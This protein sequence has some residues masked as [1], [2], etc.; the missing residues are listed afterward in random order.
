MQL[1]R[2]PTFTEVPVMSTQ[3]INGLTYY[4]G[5]DLA[6]A[7]KQWGTGEK[8]SHSFLKGVENATVGMVDG[9][10]IY[11]GQALTAIGDFSDSEVLKKTGDLLLENGLRRINEEKYNMRFEIPVEQ[12]TW[13]DDLVTQFGQLLPQVGVGL[14]ASFVGGPVLGTAAGVGQAVAMD[15]ASSA[16]ARATKALEKSKQR[17][18]NENELAMLNDEIKRLSMDESEFGKEL[19]EQKIKA[20]QETLSKGYVEE[21]GIQQ[22]KEILK[23]NLQENLIAETAIGGFTGVTEAIGFGRLLNIFKGNKPA[24]AFLKGGATEATTEMI[25][26]SFQKVVNYTD[27]TEDFQGLPSFFQDIFYIGSLAFVAGGATSS[28][29][30]VYNKRRFEKELTPYFESQGMSKEEAQKSAGDFYDK[31]V[32]DASS[33]VASASKFSNDYR[34]K[35][36]E[37]YQSFYNSS[38][39]ALEESEA[40]FFAN[41]DEDSKAQYVSSNAKA[42]ANQ[43]LAEAFTRDMLSEDIVSGKDIVYSDGLLKLANSKQTNKIIEIQADNES[44]NNAINDLSIPK[45][46]KEKIINENNKETEQIKKKIRQSDKIYPVKGGLTKKELKSLNLNKMVVYNEEEV[47]LVGFNNNQAVVETADGFL[48]VPIKE[49]KPVEEKIKFENIEQEKTSELEEIKEDETKDFVYVQDKKLPVNY[50]IVELDSLITSNDTTG[51]VN[52]E[53]P[54]YLQNRD[55]S[56]KNLLAQIEDIANNIRPADVGKSNNLVYGSP[57]VTKENFVAVGNGRKLGIEKAYIYGKQGGYTDYLKSLGYD[58]TGFDKPILVRRLQDDYSKE[59]M[60]TLTNQAND[61]PNAALSVSETAINDARKLTDDIVSL[62]DSNFDIDEKPNRKFIVEAFDKIIPVNDKIRFS[63]SEG[64]ITAEGLNRIRNAT[65]AYVLPNKKILGDILES[66]NE[67]IKKSSDAI[68]QSSPKIVSFENKIKEGG[69]NKDYSIVE[70]LQQAFQLY[71]AAKKSGQNVRAYIKNKDMFTSFTEEQQAITEIFVSSKSSGQIRNLINNYIKIATIEGDTKQEVLF[72]DKKTKMQIIDS[73]MGKEKLYQE[74]L[75]E[76]GTPYTEPTIN[77][78]GVDR[79]TTNSTGKPIGTTKESLEAFYNWFGDSKVVDEDGRPLVVYHGTP[80]ALVYNKD[81]VKNVNNI[82]KRMYK[83]KGIPEKYK[84]ITIDKMLGWD[85]TINQF[86]KGNPDFKV[87]DE[88]IRNIKQYVPFDKFDFSM[89]GRNTSSDKGSGIFFSPS[90][91][92]AETF[93]YN[94]KTDL[95]GDI[96]LRPATA[97]TIPVYL[98]L[99]NPYIAKNIN[100]KQIA[101]YRDLGYDGII[102]T[103]TGKKRLDVKIDKEYIAFNPNQIKSTDNTTFRTDTDNIY[104]QGQAAKP[105]GYYDA[106]NKA[107]KLFN[108]ANAST[109]PH[110]TAHF[111]L[112]NMWEYVRSGNASKEYIDRFNKL[113]DFIGFDTSNPNIPMTEISSEKFATAY[114]QYLFKGVSIN[115]I[116]KGAFDNFDKWLQEVYKTQQDIIWRAGRGNNSVSGVVEMTPELE[117]FFNEWTTADLEPFSV[118][119]KESL[120]E[121]KEAIT[122]EKESIEEPT[123]EEVI[124]PKPSKEIIVKDDF[125]VIKSAE[126]IENIST[127][128]YVSTATKVVEN[129][130]SSFDNSFDNNTIEDKEGFS[131]AFEREKPFYENLMEQ[132]IAPL[133]YTK[134]KNKEEIDKAWTFVN[135]NLEQARKVVNGEEAPNGLLK[136]AVLSAYEIKMREMGNSYEALNALRE[137]SLFLTNAGQEIQMEGATSNISLE[138]WIRNI[139]AG[140][141]KSTANRLKIRSSKSQ[142]Y[143]EGYREE[144]KKDARMFAEE[145]SKSENKFK[146]LEQIIK[147]IDKKYGAGI[148]YQTDINSFMDLENI[149]LFDK[150]IKEINKR[151]GADLE[152]KDYDAIKVKWENW[153]NSQKMIE[154]NGNPSPE[155]WKAYR[156]L[157]DAVMALN[158]SSMPSLF[159]ASFSRLIML[160][161]I[162]SPV[163]N[164]ESNSIISISEKITKRASKK[165]LNDSYKTGLLPKQFKNDYFDYCSDVYNKSHINFST[166]KDFIDENSFGETMIHAQGSGLFRKV[167]RGLANI[168]FDFS[169]GKPDSWFKD[170]AFMDTLDLETSTQAMNEGLKGEEAIQRAVE[171]AKDAILLRPETALGKKIRERAQEDAHIATYTNDTFASERAIKLR[172]WLDSLAPNVMLGHNLMAFVKTVANVVSSGLEYSGGILK[173]AYNIPKIKNELNSIRNKERD[174]FSLDVQNAIN[175]GIRNGLGMILA[176]AILSVLDIEDYIPEYE[177]A[178]PSEK[179]RVRAVNGTYNAIKINGVWMSLEYF[180]P[181]MVPIACILSAKREIKELNVRGSLFDYVSEGVSVE[182]ILEFGSGY[183]KGVGSQILKIPGLREATEFFS[184][185]NDLFYAQNTEKA[186]VMML[187]DLYSFI[188][189]RTIPGIVGDVA[190][191]IDTKERD[192]RDFT[193]DGEE[194][195]DVIAKLFSVIPLLRETLPEAYDLT[196]GEPKEEGDAF[197]TGLKDLLFGARVKF[198]KDN[199]LANE[200]TRLKQS[201]QR[202]SLSDPTRYGLFKTLDKESKVKIR[203]DFAKLYYENANKLIRTYQY[204]KSSDEEKANLLNKSRSEVVKKL[205]NKYIKR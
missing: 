153:Q 21:E 175:A 159:V 147:R 170:R 187:D 116:I 32:Y 190:K 13:F 65:F 200:F 87:T 99:K 193:I 50:E 131:K 67:V 5:S 40:D 60:V 41:M 74:G 118:E 27:D 51:K 38:Y 152:V 94:I 197:V 68:M 11:G 125:P 149:L 33:L 205:K 163:L 86:I 104:L 124:T 109:L 156:K 145:L 194:Y 103:M 123:A 43:T 45:E 108:R 162:K 23:D 64:F 120:T 184:S 63:D 93:E 119:A 58:L 70:D 84:E 202:F 8:L 196:T 171:I 151:S 176:S 180:G 191:A 6:G 80:T 188:Q 154:K 29:I 17:A 81:Y 31:G 56:N 2:T 133:M 25:Q 121:E 183:L 73:L 85:E 143:V 174:S 165:I 53:Y 164:V 140:R 186:A 132:E 4:L 3:E 47:K 88:E 115:P 199:P 48:N 204:K 158:P 134:K 198:G 9:L 72:R 75:E 19:R 181:L 78:K 100:E 16:E 35:A 167:N 26:E 36:G 49:L 12:M 54:A 160:L 150:F 172:R 101:K 96:I 92:Q 37:L 178:F 128:E 182:D 69:I 157:N 127:E 97:G 144:V 102:N 90:K 117:A 168:V 113:A 179:D 62:Y 126:D 22:A 114:E 1:T 192:T 91:A 189:S 177:R 18:L 110:E 57:L 141:E 34:E 42:F 148:F 76:T 83:Y 130:E 129:I 155:S 161:S 55:R 105:H 24:I 30:N 166:A 14:V 66:G 138:W 173:T 201:N 122:E 71:A 10:N 44:L 106:N 139:F 52:K 46:Q 111:W 95:L 135:E 137:K 61:T 59:T 98:S 142:S 82:I 28:A 185:M 79:P 7:Q 15:T 89:S 112:D 107:I 136:T 77:I 146:T 169:L 39:K 20:I 195:P 203:Q